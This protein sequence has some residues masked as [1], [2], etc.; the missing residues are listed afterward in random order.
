VN[1]SERLTNKIGLLTN[2]QRAAIPRI[3]RALADGKTMES[4]LTGPEKVCAWTTWYRGPRGWS[5][6]D[7]FMEVLD[8]ARAEHLQGLLEKSVNEAAE[9][10]KLATP[11]A[12]RLAVKMLQGVM[13]GN[14]VEELPPAMQTLLEIATGEPVEVQGEGDQVKLVYPRNRRQAARDLLR[15]GER[16]LADVLD[17]ADL[18]TAIKQAGSGADQRFMEWL[19]QIRG[20]GRPR[21]G[22]SEDVAN[23][24]S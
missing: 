1:F 21:R 23:V 13:F 5:H 19:E 7:L 14:E 12:A 18:K 9:E 4:L 10:L 15:T 17:R 8:E 2:K 11:L 20:S 24:G 22:E 16:V 3:V 6:Q